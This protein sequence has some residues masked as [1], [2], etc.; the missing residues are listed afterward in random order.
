MA[1]L[2]WSEAQYERTAEQLEAA[3]LVAIDEARIV[4]AGAR[5]LDLGCGTGNAALEAARRGA[6]VVAIDPAAR[7]VD[8]TRARAEREGLRVRA[9]VGDASRIPSDDAAFDAVVSV[10]AV[11]FAPDA[12]RAADEMLRV[13]KPGGRIVITS[14]TPHGP[15]SKAGALLRE[16][17]GILDPSSKTRVGP[18]WG[19]PKFCHSLFASRNAK[20]TVEERTLTFTAASP[21][22]WFEEQETHHPIW[23]GIKRALGGAHP[24]EWARIR[25]RSIDVMREGNEDPTGFRTTSTY[26]LVSVER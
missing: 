2:D 19:D 17:M 24:A 1:S 13:T 11:I 4:G 7:L 3:S 16:G 10:F 26:L 9:E 8:V 14:W 23:S 21:E 20:V 15:I 25:A 6:D 18:A 22:A 5:V 12:D